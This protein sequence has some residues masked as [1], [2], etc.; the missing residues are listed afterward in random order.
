MKNKTD[1]LSLVYVR[2]IGVNSNNFFEYEFF[3]SENPETVWGEDWNVTCPSACADL[4]P[5]SE[6]YSLVKRLKTII[7]LQCVQENSCFSIADSIDD[8]IALCFEDINGYEEYPE[9]YRL[10]FKF[11]E[12]Y[13][14][15]E[16]KL[17]GRH[18]LF[19]DE[20]ENNDEEDKTGENE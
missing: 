2:P 20:D 10:V 9:P 12:V 16:K 8:I 4:T 14:E 19:I 11:G 18:Q 3:F 17:A 7:P 15:V 5:P 1:N 13:D 6:Q